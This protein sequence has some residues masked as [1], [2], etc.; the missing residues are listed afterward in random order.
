MLQKAKDKSRLRI[1][2][3]DDDPMVLDLAKV[4]LKFHGYTRLELTS[5]PINA[6]RKLER[7][8]IDVAFLDWNLP[9]LSGVDLVKAVRSQM[10]DIPI[11]MV[12]GESDKEKVVEALTAGATDYI[13]KPFLRTTLIAKLEE[14]LAKDSSRDSGTDQQ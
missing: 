14:A 11:I 13:I 10:N 7:K 6:M 12:T 4:M 2:V 1:L 3:L 9:R 8:L 5:D